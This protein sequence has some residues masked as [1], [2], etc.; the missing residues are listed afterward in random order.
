MPEEKIPHRNLFLDSFIK[1]SSD[2]EV[3]FLNHSGSPE[4]LL[5]DIQ[6]IDLLA[7]KEY[8]V[9]TIDHIKTHPLVAK[10]RVVPQYRY[11]DVWVE[12]KDHTALRFRL[13]RTLI[14]RGLRFLTPAEIRATKTI[15]NFGMPIPSEGIHFEYLILTAQFNKIHLADRYRN[16]FNSLEFK[17]RSEIFGHIHQRLS[18]V[19]H[20]LDD[21]YEYSSS[22]LFRITVALRKRKGNSLLRLVFRLTEQAAF[23][24]TK[25]LFFK[26]QI[27]QSQ[28][29]P[30]PPVEK[31]STKSEIQTGT[32]GI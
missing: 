11:S 27:F 10:V 3:I 17:N 14:R 30:V 7:E 26:E 21:L 16:H 2:L 8:S 31:D 32:T 18:L 22:M 24:L 20:K 6:S 13:I 19:I 9:R 4:K 25:N 28:Y 12:F 23:G 5:T 1:S 15:N 29:V